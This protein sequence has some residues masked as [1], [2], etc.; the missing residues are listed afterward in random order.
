MA[1]PR[2]GQDVSMTNERRRAQNRLAQ[3]RHR[4]RQALEKQA[5][6]EQ[7]PATHTGTM[8]TGFQTGAGLPLSDGII[9][10]DVIDSL[11]PFPGSDMVLS[12]F[13]P[14][15]D[16]SVSTL[17]E[18]CGSVISSTG[19]LG[20]ADAADLTLPPSTWSL[21][22][23]EA[24][25]LAASAFSHTVVPRPNPTFSN[26]RNEPLI[27]TAARGNDVATLQLLTQ[28]GSKLTERDYEGRTALHAAY[29][30]NH[31]E[32]ILWLLEQGVDV[33]AV[34]RRGRTTLSMAVNNK[35]PVGVKLM[36]VHGASPLQT[37]VEQ[38]WAQ[39]INN[40]NL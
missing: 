2:P 6:H 20:P 8:Q 13:S 40:G 39:S 12:G 3:R 14:P 21:E 29:E 16:D 27:H 38:M 11:P 1:T 19:L 26:N 23:P 24:A 37:Q 25:R 22:A 35:C 36:L 9:G 18:S 31:M 7:T 32:A 33:N 28:A 5:A 34:D 17:A 30:E 15:W 10:L 4:Q